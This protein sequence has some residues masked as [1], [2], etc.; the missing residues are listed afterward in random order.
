MEVYFMINTIFSEYSSLIEQLRE[1]QYQINS[2]PQGYISKKKIKGKQYFY[3]QNR[4]NGK[5]VSKYIKEDDVEKI[6]SEL[7]LSKKYKVEI[8][9]IENR[10]LELEQAVNDPMK[11]EL[12]SLFS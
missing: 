3:L 9:Q 4:V 6:S 5:V 1:M 7:E 12:F 11:F 8:P 10:L 2:L